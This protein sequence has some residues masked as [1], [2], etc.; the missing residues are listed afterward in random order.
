MSPAGCPTWPARGDTSS[1][2][3]SPR[4]TLWRAPYLHLAHADRA[5]VDGPPGDR[6]PTSI[7]H[8]S[9]CRPVHDAPVVQQHAG[10][11]P[12]RSVRVRRSTA[13]DPSQAEMT[14]PNHTLRPLGGS[15]PNRPRAERLDRG[16]TRTSPSCACSGHAT[17][18]QELDDLG[19]GPAHAAAERDP[20]REPGVVDQPP[21]RRSTYPTVE[22]DVADV[23]VLRRSEVDH[24]TITRRVHT[25]EMRVRPAPDATWQAPDKGTG[26]D[27]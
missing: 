5:F 26:C 6:H 1:R 21:R 16:R 9:P 11:Q 4:T 8:P 23:P 14:R 25:G 7:Q 20:D 22:L 24:G 12:F 15:P 2:R 3:G 10:D 19:S 27:S 18:L 13:L 17:G